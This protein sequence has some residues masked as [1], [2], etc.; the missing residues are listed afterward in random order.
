MTAHLVYD[1]GSL[2]IIE[3]RAIILVERVGC[4]R[5]CEL[6]DAMVARLQELC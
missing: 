4:H 6:V 5:G 2:D 3:I 1:D